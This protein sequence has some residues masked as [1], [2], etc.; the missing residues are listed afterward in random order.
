MELFVEIDGC[1]IRYRDTG[2]TSPV[3]LLTHGIGSSLETWMAQL[4]LA[5][6]QQMRL[7]AWDVPGHGLSDFGDQPYGP[8]KFAEVAWRF[9]NALGVDKAILAGN[10]MGG[11]IS[12]HMAGLQPKRALKL[13]LLN[14]ATLGKE[15]PLPFRM[16]TLPLLGDLMARPG[17][18]AVDQQIAA[19][20][21]DQSAVTD[22]VR[23]IATRNVM[24]PGAQ[25]AFL[26]TIRQ[27]TSLTGQRRDLVDAS[28]SLLSSF[29]IP[30]LFIHGRQDAVLPL[31]HSVDAQKRT[32]LSKLVILEDCGHTPQIEKPDTVF[33]ILR[34]FAQ[35]QVNFV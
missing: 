4:N 16:M 25:K 26:A 11:A 33:E 22:S 24:R 20:F 31:Q 3:V 2:G 13:L 17:Q 28:L 15:T 9:L 10:S 35:D 21:Y 8:P 18:A 34:D 6:D 30:V 23:E 27:M 19:I 12:V 5:G 29:S 7:I 1:N 14:A 32:P